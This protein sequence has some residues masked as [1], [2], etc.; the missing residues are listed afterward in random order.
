MRD[1]SLQVSGARG[2][3]GWTQ[4]HRLCSTG[5]VLPYR[6]LSAL[7]CYW[8]LGGSAASLCSSPATLCRAPRPAR[9]PVPSW[10]GSWR[11]PGS[12]AWRCG[13]LA[14]RPLCGAQVKDSN[15][16]YSGP[17]TAG[18]AAQPPEVAGY[19]SAATPP[20]LGPR[21]GPRRRGA[22]RFAGRS[23]CPP[24]PGRLRRGSGYRRPGPAGPPHPSAGRGAAG[25]GRPARSPRPKGYRLSSA[26]TSGPASGSAAAASSGSSTNR[27]S[28]YWSMSRRRKREER[29]LRAMPPA[30]APHR[31]RPEPEA[32]RPPRRKRKRN[33]PGPPRP[34]FAS[35]PLEAGLP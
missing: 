7:G 29:V 16:S 34:P 1:F 17:G 24:R 18:A 13:K 14:A 4:G 2:R 10:P 23:S 26:S 19:A 30:G 28:S 33:P 11:W 20:P 8:D 12:C 5:G 27:F 25:P 3:K 9:A 35:A 15:G 31:P 6:S 21:T 32:P 22:K